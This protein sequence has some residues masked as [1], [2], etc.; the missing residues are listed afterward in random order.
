VE[1]AELR[2]KAFSYLVD[3]CRTA[4]TKLAVSAAVRLGEQ[5]LSIAEFDVER[6]VALEVVGDSYQTNYDGSQA[7]AALREALELRIRTVPEDRRAIAR[8]SAKVLEAPTRWPGSMHRIPEHTELDPF[9]EMGLANAGEGDS[10][11]LVQLLTAKAFWPFAFPEAT[12]GDEDATAMAEADS[13]AAGERAAEMAMRLGRPD[14][15]SAVLDALSS[16]HVSKGMYGR[17]EH[18]I[19]RRLELATS[20]EDPWEL[21]DIFATAAWNAFH[22]GRYQDAVRWADEGLRRGAEGSGVRLHSVAWRIVALTRLGEWDRALE[23]VADAEELLGDRRDHPPGFAWRLHGAAAFIHDVHGN[24]ASAD[25]Y[26]SMLER[27][28]E[29]QKRIF[30]GAGPWMATVRLRRGE[31]REVRDYVARYE[32]SGTRP[33]LGAVYEVECELI[34]AA[35]DWGDAR[36]VVEKARTH[37]QEAGLLALPAFADRLE[38]RTALATGEVRLAVQFLTS[39]RNTFADLEARWEAACTN[40]SLAEAKIAA[41]DVPGAEALVR[42]AVEVFEPLRSGRELQQAGE[43]LARLPS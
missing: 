3:A 20:I 7:H 43:L 36:A 16:I 21:G 19:A 27:I 25:R 28:G 15:A 41:D 37:A 26:L 22:L 29:E 9:L 24:R 30:F 5:A 33:D 13:M 34:A 4:R 12:L 40:L 18:I 2:Q 32:S 35:R 6:A 42:E 23:D 14:L 8:L 17:A 38:G 11:E 1:V 39:A 10:V 31:F